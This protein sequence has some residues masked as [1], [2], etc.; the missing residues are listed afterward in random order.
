MIIDIYFIF[1]IGGNLEKM[2]FGKVG[3]NSSSEKA[4][5][6]VYSGLL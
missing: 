2:I 4:G 1:K 3:G 6:T 5:E